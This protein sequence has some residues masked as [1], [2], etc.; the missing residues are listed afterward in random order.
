[1]RFR[2][3]VWVGAVLAGVLA[4]TGCAAGPD[5]PVDGPSRGHLLII[6]GGLNDDNA[7]I[8]GRFLELAGP[9][10]IGII[11]TASGDPDAGPTNAERL[12]RFDPGRDVVVI[13]LDKDAAARADDPAVAALIRSCSGLWFT[14]GDQSRITAVFRPGPRGAAR[15][16]EAYRATL[17]V[18]ARGGVIAG[19]SAGAA[20]MSDPMITG[21]TSADA[22]AN[23]A[24]WTDQPREGQGVGLA[25]GLGYFPV[26]LTDQHFLERGRLG[27]LV[28][29]L[30][31]TGVSTGFGVA[32]N[33]ALEVDLARAVARAWGEHAVTVVSPAAAG[34]SHAQTVSGGGAAS[35]TFRLG[36]ALTR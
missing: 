14:G 35:G 3:G 36:P 9:G 22:L 29:A 5:R 2:S 28:V 34:T 26:G 13:P 4:L 11:P 24:T 21:G 15:D 18:L 12:R 31:E 32:E 23:G 17:D 16:T 10:R 1:V 7:S 27:R 25:P 19:T 20:V 8:S 33:A 30:R 6:G